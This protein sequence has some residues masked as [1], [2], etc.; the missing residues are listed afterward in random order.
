[1]HTSTIK[2][3]L[4]LQSIISYLG[5]LPIVLVIIDFNMLHFFPKSFLDDFIIF[6]TLLLF[7]F[8]GSMR[9]NFN[10]QQNIFYILY[11]FI[12]SLIS[13]VL[14]FLNLLKFDKNLL[15]LFI[16]LSLFLQLIGDLLIY[17]YILKDKE[18]IFFIRVPVTF[19]V[20]A[21]LIYLI[22]V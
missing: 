21:S 12:P 9:W 6:Y 10:Q 13:T 11:G 2:K 22:V 3:I 5:I 7:S 18:F 14:I 1:M 17:R 4:N 16:F 15:F 20:L 19:L 8:I